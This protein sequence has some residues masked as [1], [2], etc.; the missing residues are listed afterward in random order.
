MTEYFAASIGESVRVMAWSVV[1]TDARRE[2]CKSK[3]A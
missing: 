2:Y 1:G 3:N